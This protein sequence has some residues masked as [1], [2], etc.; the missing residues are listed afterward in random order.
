ST[1]LPFAPMPPLD[2]LERQA[3][4]DLFLELGPEAP[5]L[6]AGWRTQELAAHLVLREHFHRW[7]DHRLRAEA[8]RGYDQVVARVRAGAPLVPWRIPGLRTLLNGFEFF[9]H[10]ED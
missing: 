5:T 4:C 9:V 10:H 7:P 8:D 3:L 1:W 6:C 2:Q